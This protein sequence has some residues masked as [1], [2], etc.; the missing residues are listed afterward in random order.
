V[1]AVQRRAPS[2]PGR[3]RQQV[4]VFVGVV[5]VAALNFAVSLA[6]SRQPAMALEIVGGTALL[7]VAVAFPRALL[8][9]APLAAFFPQRVGPAELNLSVTDAVGL[10][11]ALAALRYVPWSDRRIRIVLGGLAIYLGALAVTLIVHHPQRA[12]LE[13]GHRGALVAGS[14]FIGVAVVRSGQ[15]RTALRLL[16]GAGAIVAATAVVESVRT[17]FEPAYVFQLQKNHAGLVLATVW[18][19]VWVARERLEWHPNLVRGLQVLVL[20]GLLAT[21]SRASMLGLVAA[22]AVRPLLV[23]AGRRNER[24]ISIGVLAL[25]L[26]L[27]GLTAASVQASDLSRPAD[28]QKFNSINSRTN[29][30]EEAIQKVWANNRFVGGGLRYF[31]DPERVYPTPHNLFIGELAEAGVIGLVGLLVLLVALLLALRRSPSEL[32]VLGA[33][34]L[35]LRATQGLADIYWVAGPLTIGLVLVGMGLADDPTRPMTPVGPVTRRSRLS[36][37]ATSVARGIQS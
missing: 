14:V 24:A 36:R 9:L 18:L 23:P 21:Q 15:A 28:K 26:A 31:N 8:V 13:W 1:S 17:G 4:V 2:S 27:L 11:A 29:V 37:A 6:A 12:V 25:C 33:M 10:V 20:L 19:I 34:A 32:A 3:T 22:L 7:V 30:Y 5:A 16:V 35:V